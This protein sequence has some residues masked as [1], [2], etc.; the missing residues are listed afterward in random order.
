MTADGSRYP[1]RT[2]ADELGQHP[3][4]NDRRLNRP[5]GT[6]KRAS[7]T[8][9]ATPSAPKATT[10]YSRPQRPAHSLTQPMHGPC[11]RL[12][13]QAARLRTHGSQLRRSPAHIRHHR[14][15]ETLLCYSGR[16]PT[17]QR[18]TT[19]ETDCGCRAQTTDHRLPRTSMGR[20]MLSV[21]RTPRLES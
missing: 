15:P 10:A 21:G 2:L 18:P 12:P 17:T 19:V 8:P 14:R 11:P 9:T 1:D 4:V 6:N 20:T 5:T 3:N 7:H 13:T 16:W